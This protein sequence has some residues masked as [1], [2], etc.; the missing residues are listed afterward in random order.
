MET[1]S[2][3]AVAAPSPSP[4]LAT[5]GPTG[6]RAIEGAGTS[7]DDWLRWLDRRRL[8]EAAPEALVPPGCR[9]VVVAPHPDD[10]VLSVGGLFGRL[11]R[12]GRELL[13]V[14]ATDGTGSH[15][16]SPLWPPKR[17]ARE[18]PLETAEALRRLDLASCEV[19]RLGLPDGGLMRSRGALAERVA[20]LLRPGDVVF[21]TWRFDG[22]PD[23]EATG[24]A[25][26]AVA[27]CMG[28]TL[29]EVPVWAW[30]W[31][32]AGDARLPWSRARRVALDADT[33]HR[34]AEAVDAFRSQLLPDESTGAGPI[35]RSTTVER[36]R[37]PFEVVFT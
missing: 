31:A 7:E 32:A 21:T 8:P 19:R 36:A 10:E 33:A 18:R 37:R 34:K 3:S 16:G 6:D 4:A 17:L 23:H 14:A 1:V 28:V 5:A 13:V 26:A 24:Q 9:A 25:C 12:L 15:D 22:H 30:H 35:L 2:P 11:H 29:V 27:A 20:A